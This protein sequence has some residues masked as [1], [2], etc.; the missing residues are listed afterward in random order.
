[1]K[2]GILKALHY[3][4][5]IMLAVPTPPSNATTPDSNTVASLECHP[6]PGSNQ[7]FCYSVIDST[8]APYVDWTLYIRD[9]GKLKKHS[10]KTF[11]VAIPGSIIFSENGFL[12]AQEFTEEG[13]PHYLV[14]KTDEFIHSENAS[15]KAHFEDYDLTYIISLSDDGLLTYSWSNDHCHTDSQNCTRTINLFEKSPED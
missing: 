8:M 10:A 4:L 11:Q 12:V 6:R 14:Y 3:T 15:I 2:P 1:M 7:S 9:N 5:F 13:H